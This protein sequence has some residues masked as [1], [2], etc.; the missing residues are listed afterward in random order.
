MN[1]LP[2]K[3]GTY[4]G[5]RGQKVR[6]GR[7]EGLDGLFIEGT[8]STREHMGD[9]YCYKVTAADGA[10][11][12]M[13]LPERVEE[14]ESLGMFVGKSDLYAFDEKGERISDVKISEEAAS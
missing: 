12:E 14:G 10:Q 4:L 11:F 3:N 5:F 9:T 13:R 1:I 2:Q 6:I 7:P 8:V